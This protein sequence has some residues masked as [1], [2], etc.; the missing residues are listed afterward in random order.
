M[1]ASREHTSTNMVPYALGKLAITFTSLV[2]AIPLLLE[3]FSNLTML[4]E[5][6]QP[7]K[8]TSKHIVD[9]ALAS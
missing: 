1:L 6:V 8:S 5:F 2:Y 9:N 7:H 4:H 3:L